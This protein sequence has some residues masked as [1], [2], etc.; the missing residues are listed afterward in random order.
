MHALQGAW[1][2]RVMGFLPPSGLKQVLALV[3][4]SRKIA[5]ESRVDSAESGGALGVG[6]FL[7]G[8]LDVLG[9]CGVGGDL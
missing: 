8:N 1:C 3:K 7:D 9:G 2:R 5:P 6:G 4:P